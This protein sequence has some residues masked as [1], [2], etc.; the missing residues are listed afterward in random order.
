MKQ[1][2]MEDHVRIAMIDSMQCRR[3][4][5]TQ[6]TAPGTEQKWRARDLIDIHWNLTGIQTPSASYNRVMSCLIGHANPTT[7]RCQLKQK[8]IAAETGY[9]VETVKRVIKWWEV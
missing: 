4:E 6:Y 7:G 5:P 2:Y 8:L 3:E 9:S 1:R